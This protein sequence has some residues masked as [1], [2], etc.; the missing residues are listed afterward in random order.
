MLPYLHIP[1]KI[2]V[3]PCR[4]IE[5]GKCMEQYCHILGKLS[6]EFP[7]VDLEGLKKYYL[8]MIEES[9]LAEEFPCS[10]DG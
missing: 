7:S 10:D 9:R 1:I 2:E 8:P 6:R 4:T 3:K 5:R